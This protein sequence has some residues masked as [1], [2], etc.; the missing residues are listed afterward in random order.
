M[1]DEFALDYD[2]EFA[3]AAAPLPPPQPHYQYANAAPAPAAAPA[4]PQQIVVI[5]EAVS[6]RAWLYIVLAFVLILLTYVSVQ[7]AKD[8]QSRN[9]RNQR[10]NLQAYVEHGMALANRLPKGH[11]ARATEAAAKSPEPEPDPDSEEEV[12]K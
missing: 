2:D 12:A 9:V 4:P 1:A 7:Y 8:I 6:S 3:P 5:P 10:Y 11:A